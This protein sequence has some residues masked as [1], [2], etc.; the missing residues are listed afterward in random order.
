MEIQ[1]STDYPLGY[2]V[3]CAA[4][5][6]LF[7]FILYFRDKR[8]E[9]VSDWMK[10]ALYVLRFAAVFIILVLLL[11]PF[12]KSSVKK[13]ESPFIIIAQ[14]ES[15]SIINSDSSHFKTDYKVALQDAISQ[16]SEDFEVATYGFGGEVKDG[17]SYNFDLK[18][19][20]ISN[21]ISELENKYENRNVGAVIIASDGLFNK[22]ANPIYTPISIQAPIYSV[23][24]GDTLVKKDLILD[25]VKYNRLAYLGNQFPLEVNMS[26]FKCEDEHFNLTVSKKGKVVYEEEIKVLPNKQLNKVTAILKADKEGIQHYVVNLSKLTDEVTYANNRQDIYIDVLDSKQQILI[27]ADAPH[28]DL[29]ALKT[30]IETNENYEAKLVYMADFKGEIKDYSLV[31]FH[32]LPS[33][34]YNTEVLSRKMKDENVPA[35]YVLGGNT[36][37]PTFNKVQTLIKINNAKSGN[38]NSQAILSGNFSLFKLSAETE[39]HL[40]AFPPLMCR[41]GTYKTS[42]QGNILLKQIIGTVASDYP[43]V[44]YGDVNGLRTGIFTGEGLFR[45]RMSEFHEY[46]TQAGF[47]ELINKSVQ[48]LS[49]KVKRERLRVTSK[50]VYSE[51]EI[52][53]F[54]GEVYND[55]YEP[56]YTQDVSIDVY[57][58]EDKKFEYV[59]SPNQVNNEF[60][61]GAFNQGEYRFVATTQMGNNTYTSKGQFS[62]SPVMIEHMRNVADV[63]LMH[64]LA[65][66]NG[67]ELFFENQLNDLVKAIKARDDITAFSTLEHSFER[68]INQ[69]WIYF[70]VLVLVGLE[71]LIRKRSGAY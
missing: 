65:S 33:R 45:W 67:G 18:E 41:F 71:W 13:I 27:L 25:R 21:L 54:K 30:S 53:T 9:S 28:P 66:E 15:E 68:I 10:R 39:S 11:D 35:L 50:T 29:A 51:N 17:I 12:V 2:L 7:S 60:K 56:V 36:F 20:N 49:V 52:V 40:G 4:V 19:T 46:G 26:S 61:V 55:S 57:D 3:L 1:F 31:V 5:A 48:Y 32:Q 64:T 24:L 58:S 42:A 70:L 34:R 8:F 44:V 14:D 43:L 63:N 38:N 22:G 47:D 23:L 59:F 16:L 62:V 69:K 6:A 37:I